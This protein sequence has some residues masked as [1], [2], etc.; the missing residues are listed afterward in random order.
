[1]WKIDKVDNVHFEN[2]MKN[3]HSEKAC[4]KTMRRHTTGGEKIF[5]NL[6]MQQSS[7]IENILRSLKSQE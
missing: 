1:M 4:V 6:C 3:V 7:S 2:E 5:A